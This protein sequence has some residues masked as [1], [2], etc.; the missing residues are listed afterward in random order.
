M[1]LFQTKSLIISCF[2]LHPLWNE[3]VKVDKL[4]LTVRSSRAVDVVYIPSTVTEDG[5]L[6]ANAMCLNQLTWSRGHISPGQAP[7]SHPGTAPSTSP[8]PGLHWAQLADTAIGCTGGPQGCP[9]HLGAPMKEKLKNRVLT[10]TKL[11]RCMRY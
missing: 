5:D 6:P 7:S 4:E 8:G 1:Y 10:E 2:I 3:N 9:A 11:V